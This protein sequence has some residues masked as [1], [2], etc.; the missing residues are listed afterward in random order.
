MNTKVVRTRLVLGGC[1]VCECPCTLKPYLSICYSCGSPRYEKKQLNLF[2]FCVASVYIEN[3][4]SKL[5]KLHHTNT[6]KLSK[7]VFWTRTAF[8]GWL[9]CE[10]LCTLKL[11]LSICYSCRSLWYASKQLDIFLFCIAS[12]YIENIYSKLQK[13]HHT[14]TT[15]MNTK[16]V[17]TR[18]VLGGCLVCECPYTQN[19]TCPYVILAGLQGMRGNNKIFLFCIASIYIENI[20]LKLQKWYPNTTK[21]STEVVRTRMVLGGC[22]V[23]EC[24]CTLK[25]YLSIC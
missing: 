15:K 24:P 17:R 14:Y 2:L 5:Q 18:L 16:V 9:V 19:C 23:C 10:C 11:Y 21:I 8:G 20:N 13:S 1:L 6:T 4:Y 25:L 22:L 12:V 7:K 3:I